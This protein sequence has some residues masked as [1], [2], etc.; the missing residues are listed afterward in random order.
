MYIPLIIKY[1][2]EGVPLESLSSIFDH[3]LDVPPII[4]NIYMFVRNGIIY[5]ILREL[6]GLAVELNVITKSVFN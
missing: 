1:L 5:P 4:L 2:V 3:L 6:A